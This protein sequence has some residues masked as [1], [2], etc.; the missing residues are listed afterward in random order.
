MKFKKIL[1][2]LTAAAMT[3]SLGI[4]S[5]SADTTE[6]AGGGAETT[7]VAQIGDTKYETLQDAVTNATSSDVIKLIADI[8]TP[9][10]MAA[11]LSYQTRTIDLNNHN[12]TASG[13]NGVFM[14][15]SSSKLTIIGDG[16]VTAVKQGGSAMAV[17]ANWLNGQVVINGGTYKQSG[18]AESDNLE[19][20]YAY[21]QG[22]VYIQGG[23]FE[24]S[25]PKWTLNL[26]DQS[27]NAKIIVTGGTF[28]GY[29]PATD[30]NDAG[31]TV[32]EGL[33][34][35]ANKDGTYV[36]NPAARI[37]GGSN[38]V[39]YAT[40][41]DAVDAVPNNST[42]WETIYLTRDIN[43]DGTAAYIKDKTRKLKIS[44]Y[45]FNLTA[46]GY[47]GAF[48]VEN[49]YVVLHN[50]GRSTGGVVT[51]KEDNKY[52]MGVWAS[53]GAT[54]ILREL[55]FK[56][57]ITSN[58]ADDQ[59]DMIYANKDAK[60]TVESGTFESA[61]PKWT[62]NKYDTDSAKIT[63]TGGKFYQYNPAESYTEPAPQPTSFVASGYSVNADGDYFVVTKDYVAE[64]T[65]TGTKYEE[66]DGAIKAAADGATIKLLKD[67]SVD[68]PRI[69]KTIT[70]DLNGHKVSGY[71]SSSY[72]VLNAAGGTLTI[73]DSVGGGSV[74]AKKYNAIAIAVSAYN[75]A[76]LNIE[77]GTFTQEGV[78][79]SDLESSTQYDMIY[80]YDNAVVNIKGGTFKSVTPKWTLNILDSSKAKFNVTGG[81]F[82]NY[83]PA[84]AETEPTKPTSFVP[85]G[86]DVAQDSDGYY[87]VSP[88]AAHVAKI[89]EVEYTTLQ[90]AVN[91]AANGAT[92]TLISDVN[93]KTYA[94]MING[95]TLTINLNGHNITS[96]DAAI[97]AYNKANV[98]IEGDG[99][100]TAF[101]SSYTANQVFAIAV[102]ANN[103]TVN[104]N[105]GT[106]TQKI[107]NVNPTEDDF[108]LIYSYGGGVINIKGGTFK[109]LTPK[110]TLNLQDNTGSTISVSGGKFYNYN[111]ATAESEPTKPTSFVADRYVAKA[112]KSGNYTVEARAEDFGTVAVMTHGKGQL[113]LL[114]GINFLDYRNAGFIVDFGDSKATVDTTVVYENVKAGVDEKTAKDFGTNYIFGAKITLPDT[115][116]TGEHTLTITPFANVLNKSELIKA[117]AATNVNISNTDAIVS[118]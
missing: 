33:A 74:V 26:H 51:A 65:T 95:K 117:A 24:A 9:T 46:S 14:V 73:T 28:V 56:Q 63:V 71:S 4:T 62:L 85:G 111:P 13:E 50:S 53:K 47:D 67:I 40:L 104:I 76:V 105:G 25:A 69:T 22:K 3:L 58:P 77:G 110:W 54:V 112:D 89:G 30:A 66:F 93:T 99:T 23:T 21:A 75:D 101:P 52:A 8:N 106:Y 82:Y 17:W 7:Y 16:I 57:E 86:Y 90:S 59:Y 118:E 5:V 49:S 102:W 79:D 64:N 92:I 80:A 88:T 70:L 38:A 107:E 91:G 36:V 98:T 116:K 100:V 45:G 2:L 114:S 83:N 97:Y 108:A 12:I 72:G 6:E 18:V 43:T 37:G 29:N 34:V 96:G 103:A 32:A 39:Y 31:I 78:T 61:T 48:Y 20:I 115:F 44:L 1:S 41:Q 113:T 27:P 11:T 42:S 60:I 94:A 81:K 87:T 10:K 109:P 68:T 84:A 55:T 19:L 15:N 35:Q